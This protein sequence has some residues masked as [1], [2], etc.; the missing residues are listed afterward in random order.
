MANGY[1]KMNDIVE[2]LDILYNNEMQWENVWEIAED[3]SSEITRLREENGKLRKALVDCKIDLEV[4]INARYQIDGKVHP[5]L[6]R[7]YDN[8][9]ST[10]IAATKVI[11]EMDNE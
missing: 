6:Q 9:M 5:A 4:E 3:A 11:E 8:D 7:K 2:R 1:M 10:V